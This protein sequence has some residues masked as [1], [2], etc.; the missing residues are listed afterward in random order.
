M[1]LFKVKLVLTSLLA[2]MFYCILSVNAFAATDW[3]TWQG[4]QVNKKIN[5]NL[6]LGI[7]YESRYQNSG[8][9]YFTGLWVINPMFKLSKS[10]SA[11]PIYYYI[12]TKQKDGSFKDENRSGLLTTYKWA[13]ENFN[14][15]YRLLYE[16]R[17]LPAGSENRIRHRIQVKPDINWS[18]RFL[19]PYF[20]YEVFYSFTSNDFMQS[21]ICAG[22]SITI[23]QGLKLS[24]QYLLRQDKSNSVWTATNT[25]GTY[26][27]YSF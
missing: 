11:G 18:K 1:K 27:N 2:G 22:D 10:I 7:S 15:E 19:A 13:V 3:Q 16:Y 25:V 5:D 23:C 14:L 17:D 6:N 9:E 26:L 8:K 12:P 20:S 4:E 21:R 24:L